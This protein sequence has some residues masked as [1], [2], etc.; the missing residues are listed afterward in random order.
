MLAFN[1]FISHHDLIDIPLKGRS[2][3]WSNMQAD[4]LLEKLDWVFT[5]ASW[6]ALFPI[7]LA[8]PLAKLS[9]DHVPLKVQVGIHV[10]KAQIF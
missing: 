7:T 9:S 6:T 10:P 4:P 3:T 5:S 1:R 2:F 8:S